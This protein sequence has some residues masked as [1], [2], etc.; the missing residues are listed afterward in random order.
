VTTNNNVGNYILAATGGDAITIG[1]AG[2]VALGSHTGADTITFGTTTSSAS[3]TGWA[4][5]S[6]ILKVSAI[7]TGVVAATPAD[8][9]L[10]S[11][12]TG[13]LSMGHVNFVSDSTHAASEVAFYT[14]LTDYSAASGDLDTGATSAKNDIDCQRRHRPS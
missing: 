8:L 10:S 5:T 9:T 2:T 14:T 7:G 4:Y 1:T 12:S 13:T 11:G 6:D 3:V